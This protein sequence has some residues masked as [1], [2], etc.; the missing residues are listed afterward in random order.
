DVDW[1]T[2][3]F[4]PMHHY[5]K[6]VSRERFT[7]IVFEVARWVLNYKKSFKIRWARI[8]PYIAQDPLFPFKKICKSLKV[9]ILQRMINREEGL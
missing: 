9:R 7:E 2:Y 5:V 6:D 8:K 1:R 4:W 3:G